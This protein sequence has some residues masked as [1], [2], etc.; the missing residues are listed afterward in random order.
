MSTA[1]YAFSSASSS[2]SAVAVTPNTL[3][4]E[5]AQKKIKK[6]GGYDKLYRIKFEADYLGKLAYEGASR[7]Y[8]TGY[9]EIPYAKAL[10]PDEL[11]EWANGHGISKE[12]D[13]RVRFELHI[14]KTMGFPGY[15]LIVQDFI[16]SARK[17][18]G[19]WV[20]PGRGFLR[21]LLQQA[22]A[23]QPDSR[24]RR[25]AADGSRGGLGEPARQQA[26]LPGV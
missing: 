9:E 3:P 23:L 4:Q 6:L 26:A 20:G 5:D 21:L 16:N 11:S 8:G 19:V 7:L 12:V 10:Q 1:A 18:L 2:V 24:T 14:M 17:E 25:A 15:F 22:A 13:E